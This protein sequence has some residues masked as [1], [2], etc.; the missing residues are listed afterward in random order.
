[1]MEQCSSCGGG[2]GKGGCK[3]TPMYPHNWAAQSMINAERELRRAVKEGYLEG[4]RAR[5]AIDDADLIFN[6]RLKWS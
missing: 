4:E 2:C 1:M 6:M 5:Q 3:S